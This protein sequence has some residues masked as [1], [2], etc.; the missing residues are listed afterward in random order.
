MQHTMHIVISTIMQQSNG[1]IQSIATGILFYEV[2]LHQV[3]NI[4]MYVYN[5]SWS[6]N[7]IF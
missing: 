3:F 4:C 2:W 6:E 7:I 5:Q 1:L